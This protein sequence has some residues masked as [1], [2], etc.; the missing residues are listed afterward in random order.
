MLAQNRG[1]DRDWRTYNDALVRRGELYLSVDTLVNDYTELTGMNHGKR[2][3]PFTFSDSMMIPMAL[4]HTVLYLPYRQLEG[5]LRSLSRLIPELDVPDYSTLCRRMKR[6]QLEIEK[7][8]EGDLVVALDPTGWKVTNRGEWMREKWKRRRGWIKVHIAVDVRSKRL[9][10]VEITDERVADHN[11]RVV[12]SLLDQAEE[13]CDG[14]VAVMGD[15]GFDTRETFNELDGRGIVPVIKM[16]R[17]ASTRSK[18]CP[19]RAKMVRERKR[20]GEEEW[21]KKYG[22]GMRWAVEGFFSGVK[23]VMGEGVRASSREGM[24]REVMMKLIF[25]NMLL[26]ATAPR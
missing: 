10:G 20:I 17:N 11:Q 26:K 1:R 15:G 16:R 3:R 19:S 2:G 5:L 6:V 7:I 21:K 25:Y 4:L 9:L 13:N 14:I 18:G 8:P 12:R 23:R 24:E 22:Y